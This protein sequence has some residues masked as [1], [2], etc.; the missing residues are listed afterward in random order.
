MGAGD[1]RRTG[2]V[3]SF[4]EHVG[5]GEI[6]AEDGSIVPFQCIVIADG[7]RHIDIGVAVTFEPL[8]KLGRYEAANVTRS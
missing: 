6:A 1:R 4:D 5:L 2:T 8:P 7:T 3:T